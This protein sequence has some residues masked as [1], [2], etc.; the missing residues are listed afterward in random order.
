MSSIILAQKNKPF[1]VIVLCLFQL[2]IHIKYN[3]LQYFSLIIWNQ[4]LAFILYLI[5]ELILK[6]IK[7]PFYILIITWLFFLP[8]TLYIITDFIDLHHNESAL[9][10]F[11]KILIF[12]YALSG[13]TLTALSIKNVLK[14]LKISSNLSNHV[15]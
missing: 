13:L 2:I 8:N 3:E 7:K 11:D 12:T 9:I 10:L 6:T 4:F 15:F 5:S 14:R 1:Y